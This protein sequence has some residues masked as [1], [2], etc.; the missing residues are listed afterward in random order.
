MP[1]QPNPAEVFIGA[2]KIY[3]DRFDANGYSTGMR[4]WGDASKFDI[5]AA[6]DKAD[7]WNHTKKQRTKLIQIT[8]T[9]THTMTVD[10]TEPNSENIALSVL[11]TT[12]AYTQAGGPITTETLASTASVSSTIPSVAS[13]QANTILQTAQRNISAV[14][15]NAMVASTATPLTLGTDYEIEDAIEGTIRILKIDNFPVS[16]DSLKINYTAA[17]MTATAAKKLITAGLTPQI[18][19]KVMY[20]GDP[21][22][23][24][25]RTIRAWKVHIEPSSALSLI[26][27]DPTTLSLS[28]EVLDDSINHPNSPLYEII[29][30]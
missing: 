6:I 12:A 20:V 9:Q 21:V 4:F 27:D 10:L 13:L 3:F 24:V 29:S 19:G 22:A 25:A 17:A 18:I 26:S 7:V 23:G 5:T 16:M 14:T 15:L 8:K 1:T 2:G 30:R 28:G 11:G